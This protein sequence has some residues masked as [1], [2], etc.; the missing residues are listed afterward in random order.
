[1]LVDS[2][3]P[4]RLQE[5]VRVYSTQGPGLRSAIQRT[6]GLADQVQVFSSQAGARAMDAAALTTNGQ[7]VGI[8]YQG[9]VNSPGGTW[10]CSLEFRNG[11]II[12]R[13]QNGNEW[14]AAP[15]VT[16][17]TFSTDQGVLRTQATVRGA[18]LDILT[19]IN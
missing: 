15:N 8:R 12:Y 5:R 7:F 17:C 3:G 6:A 16:A 9:G 18:N 13:N 19:A 14:V 10:M 1:M 11:Q 2:Y 4:I